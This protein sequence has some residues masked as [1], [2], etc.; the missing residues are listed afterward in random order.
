MFKNITQLCT[1]ILHFIN[2]DSRRNDYSTGYTKLLKE[3][4]KLIYKNKVL[5]Y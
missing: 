3:A 4:M 1:Q 2:T 5:F